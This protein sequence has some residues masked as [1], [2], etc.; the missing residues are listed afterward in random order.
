MVL[1]LAGCQGTA[2]KTEKPI[3][4][5]VSKASV[6]VSPADEEARSDLYL[7]S[8]TSRIYVGDDPADALGGGFKRPERAALVTRLPAG[9]DDAFKF[10]GWEGND[11]SLGLVSRNR[12]VLLAVDTRE[13]ITQDFRDQTV[14]DYK[15]KLGTPREVQRS[16]VRYW[17]WEQGKV[18]LMLCSV[19]DRR[20]NLSLTSA[21]GVFPLMLHFRMDPDMA[22]KD[23][24]AAEVMFDRG[25]NHK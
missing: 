19:V 12:T 5:L 25:G 17:F 16:R 7:L 3:G 24:S 21:L 11:R 22:E 2:T 23:A 1:A 20:G 4:L 15:R 8:S 13:G 10:T 18:R 9:L 14:A 6:Q